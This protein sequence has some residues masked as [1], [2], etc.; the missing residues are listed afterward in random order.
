MLAKL[1]TSCLTAAHAKLL[2]MKVVDAAS[3]GKLGLPPVASFEIPYFDLD[4]KRTDF[5]RFRYLADTRTGFEAL[6]KKKPTRYVQE[7]NTLQEAYFP[8]LLQEK[9]SEVA[10]DI[11]Q[12][13]I[14]TEGELKAA[15]ATQHGFPTIGLGGVW[16]FRSSK[17]LIELLPA[18]KKIE[19]AGRKAVICYDSDADSNHDVVHARDA[20]AQRLTERGAVVELAKLPP[21]RAVASRALTT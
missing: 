12:S 4:G 7:K 11:T 2:G 21:R 18:L 10:K 5:R 1:E 17:N 8:P 19:W 9:W 13:I 3:M 16:S 15:C 6:T 14:I 20:L